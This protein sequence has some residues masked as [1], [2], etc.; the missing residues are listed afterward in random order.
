M[1]FEKLAKHWNVSLKE[2]KS[3][4]DF[5]NKTFYMATG[6][7]NGDPTFYGF[8]YEK[9]RDGSERCAFTL[10]LDADHGFETEEEAVK[11]LN[12]APER[13]HIPDGRAK[14]MGVPQDAFIALNR[15]YPSS[16]VATKKQVRSISSGRGAR[17]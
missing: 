12:K 5:M 7:K 2:A 9:F 16:P 6:Q 10:S 4:S 15:I 13:I 14:I 8:I 3:I 11:A 1:T 17:S